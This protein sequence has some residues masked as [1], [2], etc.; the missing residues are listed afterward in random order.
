[1]PSYLL[2]PGHVVELVEAVDVTDVI[3]SI[4]S[5]QIYKHIVT[6]V[7]IQELA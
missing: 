1:M 2:I 4:D 3:R 6:L 7:Q 5:F